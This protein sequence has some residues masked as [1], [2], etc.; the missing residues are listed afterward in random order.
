MSEEDGESDDG[1]VFTFF[2]PSFFT[3]FFQSIR[4]A[5]GVGDPSSLFLFVLRSGS[6]VLGDD[7]LSRL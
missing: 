7:D 2:H 3:F 4:L 1:S 6:L 5:S